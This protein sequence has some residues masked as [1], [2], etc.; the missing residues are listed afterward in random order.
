MHKLYELKEKLMDELEAYSQNGKFSKD[1]VEAIKYISSAIDHICNICED[2][3]GGEYSG[4]M[5]PGDMMPGDMM[6]G[7]M[8]MAGG[9]YAR[10]NRGGRSY[11]GSYA[12]G[13]GRNARRDSMG[14]Y[15]SEGYSR[16]EDD[17]RMDLQELMQ[18]APNEQVRQKLQRIMSEM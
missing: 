13:R 1:D 18:D 5:M 15:S 14:R 3:E 12:R 11:R 4:D 9:S 10:G 2:M 6:P 7:D 8:S 17:F 16:A